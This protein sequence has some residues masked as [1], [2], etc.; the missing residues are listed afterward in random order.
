MDMATILVTG[1]NGQVGHAF[2]EL[3]LERGKHQWYFK[4]YEELDITDAAAIASALQTLQPDYLIN[5]A[6]YTA[7]DRAEKESDKA[8]LINETG[9]A[10]L[11]A[12]CT[13][14]EVHLLHY[15]TDYVYGE[16]YKEPIPETASPS[17]VG[18]YAQSKLAGDQAV[19]P[20][21]TVIRTSWVYGKTGH[22]FVKTMLRLGQERNELSVVYD[23]L[24]SP[25]SATD[26]AAAT[27]QL[28]EAVIEGTLPQEKL[29]GVYH[30]SH[31]GVASWYDFATAI[32]EL[33]GVDCRVLPILSA[34]YPT[35]APRPAY[36]VLDKAKIKA[37][38]PLSI[39]HW[40]IRLAAFIKDLSAEEQSRH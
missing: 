32:M 37:A 4:G 10:R 36:S 7:V 18:I 31:E 22:N 17:P 34:A 19:L 8:F 40:R 23:Q 33:A 35:A 26:L 24:G 28:I 5:C 20:D 30:Y 38:M 14:A 15:S 11:A 13:A 9:P 29:K 2:R 27:L 6:A 12:A 3:A 39:G 1:A 21:H 16:D 25:T